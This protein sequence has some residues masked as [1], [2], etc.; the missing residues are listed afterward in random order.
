[1]GN[2]SSGDKA[3]D[4]K[5]RNDSEKNKEEG[6]KPLG[7]VPSHVDA[8]CNGPLISDSGDKPEGER[9]DSEVPVSESMSGDGG[10]CTS[11]QELS[12]ES[13]K[14]REEIRLSLM[15]CCDD[16]AEKKTLVLPAGLPTDV[17]GLKNVIQSELSIPVP[18]QKIY[19][20]SALLLD[21]D[22]LR[23]CRVR[24]GDVL[25]VHYNSEADV[26]GIQQQVELLKEVIVHVELIQPELADQK[27]VYRSDIDAHI[28][29]MRPQEGIRLLAYTYFSPLLSEESK[30]N[31]ACFA[32][33]SG[34]DLLS[35]LHALV[36][37]HPWERTPFALQYIELAILCVWWKLSA[38]L[39]AR[40]FLLDS[41]ICNCLVQS[42]LRVTVKPKERVCAPA[43]VLV[44]VNQNSLLSKVIFEAVGT[45]CKYVSVP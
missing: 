27:T 5:Q 34:I 28:N 17:E 15:L 23:Y 22:S 30:A 38:M 12:E 32:H 33:Y 37:K 26:A 16:S 7:E 19:F 4:E 20:E 10:G 6:D 36:L 43:H 1:M 2:R 39:G 45:L 3:I 41:Q 42:A 24:D 35:Q 8:S 44:G 29:R 14:E 18:C 21:H 11:S 31:V 13:A 40:M 25:H 9:Q